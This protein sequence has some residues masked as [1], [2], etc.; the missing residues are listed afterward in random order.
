MKDKNEVIEKLTMYSFEAEEGGKNALE[1]KLPP[2]RYSDAGGHWGLAR[3]IAAVFGAKFKGKNFHLKSKQ[4]KAN[5]DFQIKISDKNLCPRYTG[6]YFENIEIQP[7]PKWMRDILTNCGLQPIN[8]VV[9]IMN[10]AMLETGQPL[11]AFDYDKIGAVKNIIVRRAKKGEQ[12]ETLDN[13]KYTLDENVLVI[14]NDKNPLAIAGIKGGKTAEV[15]KN[16]KRIIVEAANFDATNIYQSSRK[17]NLITDASLRFSHNLSAELTMLAMERAGELLKEIA[18]AKSGVLQDVYPKKQPKKIIRF[19]IDEFNKFIGAPLDLKTAKNYL[20][21][22]GF[23]IKK[24]DNYS[25]TLEIPSERLDIENTHDLFEEVVRLY[26]Y[27]NLKSRAPRIHLHPSGSEDLIVLKDKIRNILTGWGISETQNYSFISQ[28]DAVRYFSH[29][30]GE[31]EHKENKNKPQYHPHLAEL[32]N[33]LSAEFQYLRP[34]LAVNLI[35]NIILNSRSEE[36]ISLFETGEVFFQ[37]K[38]FDAPSEISSLG[39]ILASKNMETFF[40]LKGVAAELLKKIG[41]VDYLLA[42]AD[43]DNWIKEIT[44]G[45]LEEKNSLKIEVGN[46]SVIGYLGK[47]KNHSDLKNWHISVLEID[48]KRLMDYV[49]GEHEYR[50]LPKYPSVM[51]DISVVA[52]YSVRA[53]DIT[54]SI[55]E[56]NLRYI[57]DVDLIDEYQKNSQRSLTFRIVFQ[58]ED[59]T[60]TDKEVNGYMEKIQAMLIKNFKVGIR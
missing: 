43:G 57:E 39:I 6:R 35:K 18:Q 34:C 51:R 19:D 33:P 50:P 53:G 29:L 45:Y 37:L 9:D 30:R 58:A 32:E 25:L 22:L 12:I 47:L 44:G 31:A 20:T 23:A 14:A 48:I 17:L 38:Q 40:Q 4:G 3:E 8:N 59:R 46:Q 13:K 54:A 10:Y 15:D 24:S 56:E 49:L 52:D 26:G 7:S 5:A 36:E 28:A 11:H 16:T 55:Q 41:V 2:N 60:L 42:P 21:S 27:N 1:V